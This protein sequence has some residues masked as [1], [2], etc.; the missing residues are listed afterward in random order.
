[1]DSW[2]LSAEGEIAAIM[3]AL[4]LPPKERA[5]SMVSF[6]SRKGARCPPSANVRMT[7]P[8]VTSD[9]LIFAPSLTLSDL[10]FVGL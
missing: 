6:E 9:L 8:S 3:Q 5:K 1:M 7:V 2:K 4:L 10:C